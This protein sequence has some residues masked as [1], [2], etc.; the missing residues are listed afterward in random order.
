MAKQ[1]A[2]EP[3]LVKKSRA[4][5]KSNSQDERKKQETPLEKQIRQAKWHIECLAHNIPLLDPRSAG[6]AA[7][8][9]AAWKA[10]LKYLYGIETNPAVIG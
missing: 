2:S 4:R 9:L 5:G 6:E 1:S 3:R 10:E 8:E 7:V